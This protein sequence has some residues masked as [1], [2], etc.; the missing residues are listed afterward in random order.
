M[1]PRWLRKKLEEQS[2]GLPPA[3]PEEVEFAI[4]YRVSRRVRERARSRCGS[5][6]ELCSFLRDECQP[7]GG[8]GHSAPGN[9]RYWLEFW[10]DGIWAWFGEPLDPRDA[11][12]WKPG[13]R[14]VFL[15]WRQVARRL[16]EEESQPAL[17][18]GGGL[19]D[20]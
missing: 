4:H 1:T 17:F 7:G 20:G 3:R 13:E 15:S 16:L 2:A 19:Q 10:P 9:E 12:P 11:K 18:A 6:E 14:F 5:L 8:V